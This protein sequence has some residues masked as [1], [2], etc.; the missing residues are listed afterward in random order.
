MSKLRTTHRIHAKQPKQYVDIGQVRATEDYRVAVLIVDAMSHK[1]LRS[2][3][4]NG[5]QKYLAVVVSV[6]DGVDGVG[7][8][9]FVIDENSAPS[10]AEDIQRVFPNVVDAELKLTIKGAK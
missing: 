3:A 9:K 7:S 10:T 8:H 5:Y 4:D 1:G 6:L 2:M